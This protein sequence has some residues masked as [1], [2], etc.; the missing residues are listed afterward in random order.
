MFEVGEI[1]VCVDVKVHIYNDFQ[2]KR[3]FKPKGPKT[4]TLGKRYDVI[5]S[6]KH[7]TTIINDRGIRRVYRTDRFK[8]LS[9]DRRAKI[10]KLKSKIVCSKLET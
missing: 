6:D 9:K 8:S 2:Q 10:E 1:I 4:I 3:L 7:K 5:E